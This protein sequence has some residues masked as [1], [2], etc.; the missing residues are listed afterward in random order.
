[1]ATQLGH[2]K[3]ILVVKKLQVLKELWMLAVRVMEV[4][5]GQEDQR[6]KVREAEPA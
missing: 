1:M 5:R 4:A 3:V 6:E 2:P